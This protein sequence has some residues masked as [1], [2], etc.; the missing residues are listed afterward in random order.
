MNTETL[1]RTETVQIPSVLG[2]N[3]LLFETRL[4]GREGKSA[5]G[6]GTGEGER[7]RHLSVAGITS[8]LEEGKKR[9]WLPT[10]LS[11]RIGLKKGSK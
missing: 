11:Q 9:C 6:G 3:I 8:F 10:V 4:T 1:N 5:M 7:E 2:L